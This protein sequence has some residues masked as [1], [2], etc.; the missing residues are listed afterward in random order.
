MR[1][2][3]PYA[4]VWALLVAMWL[5]LYETLA[6][7]QWILGGAVAA[8][9]VWGLRA[10][11]APAIRLRRPRVAAALVWLVFVDIVRS[12]VAVGLIALHPGVRGRRA[13]F[14]RIPLALRD[15]VGLAALAC[16]VTSTPGTAWA[17]YE[18]R[19]GVLTLHVLDLV[20]EAYWVRT[21]RE[22]YERRLKEIFE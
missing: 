12:N 4:F 3:L 8:A 2:S 17:G 14:V 16:I 5:V 13:G 21:V 6:P 10:L 11:Q 18:S 22:R 19:S 7:G 9:G 1:R 15:P 20:D